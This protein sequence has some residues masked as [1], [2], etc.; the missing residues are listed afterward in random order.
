MTTGAARALAHPFDRARA[1]TRPF[2]GASLRTRILGL[3]AAVNLACAGAAAVVT[4]YNA[5]QATKVEI[6]S[7][8]DIAS[9]LVRETVTRLQRDVGRLRTVADLQS[10]LPAVRH[11]RIV[12][13]D[14]EGAEVASRVAG[15]RARED[16]RV[17]VPD[18]FAGLIAPPPDAVTI[19][20]VIRGE[21][22]GSVVVEGDASDEIAEV[23]DDVITLAGL[24][25]A[26]NAAALGVFAIL[27][28]RVLAPLATLADG[29]SDLRL[30]RLQRRLE[31]PKSRELASIVE[32]FNS[33][34]Q[35]LAAERATNG[36]MS[37]R[38][39]TL[40]DDERRQI[41]KELH[42]EL[43]PCLFGLRANLASLERELAA[44]PSPPTPRMVE[45]L[46]AVS[47]LSERLAG[48]NRRLLT[49][50]R[51]MALG[52]AP[53]SEVLDGLIADFRRHHPERRFELATSGLGISY[54]EAVDLT[55]YRS[56]QEG[57]TNAIRHAACAR[58]V[59]SVE[60]GRDADGAEA[61]LLR[62]LDD[63]G[64]V[65]EPAPAGFGLVGLGERLR[66]L[67]GSFH[68]H[69]VRDGAA[70]DVVVPLAHAPVRRPEPHKA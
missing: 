36:R 7:S 66:A 18:W 59:V 33:L 60:R 1:K 24:F 32:R 4:I 62:V 35:S 30:G 6:A 65:T 27:L 69:N 13:R 15:G 55:V 3:L 70:L 26:L 22:A 47:D 8:L 34:G 64:G 41:A 45:R 43:G 46:E 5:R 40:Q 52:A 31:T 14:P 50:L 56:V 61:V 10:T 54:G 23:W 20:V 57:V 16:R 44:A 2:G 9:R 37:W 42:D 58:V 68:L 49:R 12:V 63:G 53:L 51:P 28:G 38:M 17:A 48:M 39:V 21:P 25:V 19:P 67:G 29:M 11:A